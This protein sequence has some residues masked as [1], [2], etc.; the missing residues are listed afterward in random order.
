MKKSKQNANRLVNKLAM[1]FIVLSILLSFFSFM[2]LT[3]YAETTIP[4]ATSQF[5]VNDFADVFTA[6]EETQLMDNAVNLANEHDGIQ[7]VVTTVET[8]GGDTVEN[9][10]NKMYNKYGIGKNDMGL[11]ILLSTGDRQIRVETGRAMEAYINDSKAGRFI[12]KYAIPSLK[13]NKFN[14][15]LI[16]LQEAFVSEI[17]SCV[18]KETAATTPNE[19][20]YSNPDWGTLLSIAV[21]SMGS[22]GLSSNISK[23]KQKE[24]EEQYASEVNYLRNQ[25]SNA[26]SINYSQKSSFEKQMSRTSSRLSKEIGILNQKLKNV[27]AKYENLLHEHN[28]LQDRY[29]HAEALHPGIDAEISA[30]IAE[31]IRQHDMA[32]ARDVDDAI[33]KVIGLT[34]SRDILYDLKNVISSYSELNENQKSYVTADISKVNALYDASLKLQKKYEEEK[35]IERRKNRAAEAVSSITAIIGFMTFAKA[36]DLP[37][38]KKAKSIYDNLDANSRYYFDSDTERKLKKL[39]EEAQRDKRRIEDEEEAERRRQRER[40]EEEEERRRRAQSYSSS[41]S[42]FSGGSSFGGFGGMSGGGG[43]SRGF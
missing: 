39:L 24:L 3:A 27:D 13:E 33:S 5:Y 36:K 2:P 21:A 7:V 19:K 42:S 14:V 26:R 25:L 17:I 32:I 11:L 18:E 37:A 38:L 16:N 43:A 35:E 15:G 28:T 20:E 29:N 10:A 8:L 9:Y 1:L 23:R 41:H 4:E 6:E 30:M 31:E 22:F 40:E 34:A 12:D